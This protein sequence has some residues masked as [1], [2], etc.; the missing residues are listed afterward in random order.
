MIFEGGK[1]V[2]R[3]A[4]VFVD[5][6]AVFKEGEVREIGAGEE[7]GGKCG[8]VEEEEYEQGRNPKAKGRKKAENRRPKGRR[9]GN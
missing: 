7:V 3:L 4:V 5:H 1:R 8:I 6:A 9:I 2:L